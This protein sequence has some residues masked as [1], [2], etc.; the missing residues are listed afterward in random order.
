M[1]YPLTTSQSTRAELC[2]PVTASALIRVI[3]P[4]IVAGLV[5][6]LACTAQSGVY[7]PDMCTTASTP[8]GSP[9]RRLEALC[10]SVHTPE[11]RVMTG[12]RQGVEKSFIMTSTGANTPETMFPRAPGGGPEY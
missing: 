11:W 10:L 8:Q 5:F 12:Q 4:R 6:S 2:G 9:F 3:G 1:L 7:V